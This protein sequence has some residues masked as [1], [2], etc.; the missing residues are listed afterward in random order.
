MWY[1]CVGPIVFVVVGILIMAWGARERQK[2]GYYDH[3]DYDG[4]G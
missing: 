4:I 1:N 2:S 3:V